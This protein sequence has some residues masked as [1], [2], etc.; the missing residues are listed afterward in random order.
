FSHLRSPLDL[1]SFPTRRSSDL[2]AK[3]GNRSKTPLLFVASSFNPRPDEER[4]E[5]IAGF[6]RRPSRGFLHHD[7]APMGG[8][9]YADMISATRSEEHTSELQSPDHLVCRLLR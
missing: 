1:Y 9:F 8:G 4:N 2:R 6:P 5:A 3:R 7:R